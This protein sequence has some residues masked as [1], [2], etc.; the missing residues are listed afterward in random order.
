MDNR[1]YKNRLGNEVTE[2]EYYDLG[3]FEVERRSDVTE[4]QN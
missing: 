2:S 4:L 3:F 1:A